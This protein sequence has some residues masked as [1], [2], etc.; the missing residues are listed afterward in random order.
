MTLLRMCNTLVTRNDGGLPGLVSPEAA[1]QG[2][3][4]LV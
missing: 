4:Q 2:A 3:R 1:D